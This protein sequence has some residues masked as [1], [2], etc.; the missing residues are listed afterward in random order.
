VQAWRI[1]D[2]S[3][4]DVS[5]NYRVAAV[6]GVLT[7]A[8]R[9]AKL[10]IRADSAMK[11]YDGAPL[12]DPDY[13][14][15]ALLLIEG[16]TLTAV[17]EGSIV[18]VGSVKNVVTSYMI[19]NGSRTVTEDYTVFVVD[20]TLTV[21]P[22]EAPLVITAASAEKVYDG[23]P[24]TDATYTFDA[25]VLAEGHTL[26]ATVMGSITNVGKKSNIV[27][28][29]HIMDQDGQDVTFGYTVQTADGT[30]TILPR[31]GGGG[32]TEPP[33]PPTTP[34]ALPPTTGGGNPGRP[35]AP[36]AT[37]RSDPGATSEPIKT[38]GVMPYNA[39]HSMQ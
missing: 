13:F 30:L 27:T 39:G 3:G 1:A 12:V 32:T 29:W 35:S 14:Y 11:F 28:E 34:P 18:D 19:T 17:V 5:A 36:P 37:G 7:I 16:D 33:T 38:W 26:T 22:R 24:L 25:S 10:I 23:T 2:A 6:D 8:P 21:L 15:D 9:E 4:N 31:G 20:G